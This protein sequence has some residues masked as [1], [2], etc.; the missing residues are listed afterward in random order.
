MTTKRFNGKAIYQ[1]SGKAAEY[2]AWACNFFTGCSNDCEYCYCK[3][4]VMSHV[5]NTEPRL[6]KCFKDWK[7]ALDVF[8]K[9]LNANL[10]VLRKS[11]ILFSF[12]TDPL[13][14]ETKW[15]T[16]RS[17]Q[18]ANQQ[19]VPVKILTK[20]ADFLDDVKFLWLDE[21]LTAFGFTLTGFDEKEPG[22]SLTDERIEA[23]RELHCLG[24]KTFASIEPIITP[25][26]SRNMI[27]A[28][29]GFCDLYKVGVI[30]GKGK[31]FYNRDN[32][33]HFWG[34]LTG[35]TLVGSK[36]YLKDS[37]PAYFGIKREQIKG[38]FVNADYNIFRNGL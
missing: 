13:L 4:G 6:K 20:R 8:G 34:W 14:P 1:P 9:E 35:K 5:W 11:G 25:A 31:D 16:L 38:D 37:F 33:I 10:E 32:M 19:G 21:K 29:R 30:S 27:E 22:A 18:L 24:F 26:M 12:T 15:L 3:R 17:V 7:H 23:M 28:T 36:I 2:S